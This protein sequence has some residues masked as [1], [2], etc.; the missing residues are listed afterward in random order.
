MGSW[1]LF[2]VVAQFLNAVVSL[3]DKYILTSKRVTRPIVYAFYVGAFSIFSLAIFL[4][5]WIPIPHDGLQIPSISNLSWP[6]LGIVSYSIIAGFGFIIAL[7]T[8]FSAFMKADASDVVPVVGSVSAISTLF[9][10]FLFLETSLTRNFIFGFVILVIGTMVVS[11]FRFHWKTML[12]SVI[13]GLSFGI[14]YVA[15]KKLFIATHFDNAYLWLNLGIV[16]ASFV[17]LF[18]P[19]KDGSAHHEVKKTKLSSYILIF[20]KQIIASVSAFLLLKAI[21][22]GDVSI[23]QALGGL[24]FV[25]LIIFAISNQYDK[26]FYCENCTPLQKFQKIIAVVIITGGFIVLFI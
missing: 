9:F 15:V 17:L 22:F 5:S 1:I 6:T 12:F 8:L 16:L 25:F 21:E 14:H 13:S 26:V 18:L 20:F 7:A 10:S 11:L 23:V 4:F 3:V 24:Q 2:T 19:H